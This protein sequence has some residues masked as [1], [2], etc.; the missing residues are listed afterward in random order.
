[1]AFWPLPRSLV[2]DDAYHWSHTT[3]RHSYADTV[4]YEVHV[5]GR[6]RSFMVGYTLAPGEAG[7]SMAYQAIWV[8]RKPISAWRVRP[9]FSMTRR[10]AWCPAAVT[11]MIRVRGVCAQP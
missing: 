8:P 11:P 9:H 3:P 5:S 4:I 7:R 2:I 1:M 6:S 10:E